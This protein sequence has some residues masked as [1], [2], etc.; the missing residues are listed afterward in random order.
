MKER[1]TPKPAKNKKPLRKTLSFGSLSALDDP[2][3]I[4]DKTTK[5][6]NA[7][8]DIDQFQ[9]FP[10]TPTWVPTGIDNETQVHHSIAH[11]RS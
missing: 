5:S 1:K 7:K 9:S 3:E 10:S 6:G 2:D 11:F 4:K 8:K